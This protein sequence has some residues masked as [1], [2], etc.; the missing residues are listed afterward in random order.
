[1]CSDYLLD[2]FYSIKEV[3]NPYLRIIKLSEDRTL[4]DIGYYLDE[5]SIYNREFVQH[6][7]EERFINNVQCRE[8][9]FCHEVYHNW[10]YKMKKHTRYN[11]VLTLNAEINKSNLAEFIKKFSETYPLQYNQ[12]LNIISEMIGNQEAFEPDFTLHAAGGDFSNQKLIVEVKTNLTE[13]ASLFRKDFYKLLL[14][15][16]LFF[17]E[18]VAFVVVKV[19]E[20]DLRKILEEIPRIFIETDTVYLILRYDTK[21]MLTTVKHFLDK[22][23]PYLREENIPYKE[24]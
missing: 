7:V 8:R 24:E 5:I 6:I 13:D 18:E 1:M 15:K 20:K 11:K 21:I 14:Y 4:T 22:P 2:L 10:R 3:P 16:K 12:I 17:F 23:S 19:I 9:N